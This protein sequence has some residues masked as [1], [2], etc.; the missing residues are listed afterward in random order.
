MKAIIV[1]VHNLSWM[2]I[3]M[4]DSLEATTDSSDIFLYIVDNNSDPQEVVSVSGR[5]SSFKGEKKMTRMRDNIGFVKSVNMGLKD[6]AIRR[7]IKSIFICNNDILFTNNAIDNLHHT[8]TSDHG[9]NI[10]LTGGMTS[11]PNWADQPFAQAMIKNKMDYSRLSNSIEGFAE[12]L[13]GAYFDEP[14]KYVKFLAFYCI[15]IHPEV[16]GDIGFLDENYGMGLFDDDDYCYRALS[17]GYKIAL[18]KDVYVHHY[19]NSTFKDTIGMEKYM[20]IMDKN[21]VI[22]KDKHGFDP[23]DRVKN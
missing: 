23:W 14:V 19:H 4:I 6:M 22:F 8:I 7:D 18:R 11:P 17:K 2:T 5:L 21:R 15:A 10:G 1:P 13:R 20:E 16:I 3:N 12:G 9:K